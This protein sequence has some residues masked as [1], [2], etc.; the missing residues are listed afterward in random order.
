MVRM[1][2]LLALVAFAASL[3]YAQPQG[4]PPVVSPEVHWNRSATLRI[5]APLADEVLLAGSGRFEKQRPLEKGPEGVWA[6]TTE[7][8]PGG[9]Y[10]YKFVVDGVPTMDPSNPQI[11]RWAGGSSNYFHID[12]IAP[13]PWDLRNVAHGVVRIEHYVS[14][15]TNTVRRYRVYTP[16]D[17]DRTTRSYPVLYLLHGSGDSEQEWTEFGRAHLILDN[18]YDEGKIEPM[19]VVMPYGHLSAPPDRM[20][21][22]KPGTMDTFVADI[23]ENVIPDVESK[24]RVLIDQ[25]SRAVAG[26]SMGGLQTLALSTRYPDRFGWAGV[27]SAGVSNAEQSVPELMADAKRH[28][29]LWNLFWIGCGRDDFLYESAQEL[30]ALLTKLGVEHEFVET[31]GGHDWPIWRDYLGRFTPLLFRE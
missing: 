12:G 21:F 30:D 28:D 1:F 24:F 26:L 16:P 25:R 27:F 14:S 13:Q 9:I 31:A 29:R 2:R 3:S 18:L 19:V 4:P 17:Y 22:V 7:G 8:L 5:R 23:V 15:A 6:I 11:K 20:D 10:E